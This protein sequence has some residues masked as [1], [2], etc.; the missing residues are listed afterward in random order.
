MQKQGALLIIASEEPVKMLWGGAVDS[1]LSSVNL[2]KR[3]SQE[4][5]NKLQ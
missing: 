2:V 1:E 4:F 5:I 3:F